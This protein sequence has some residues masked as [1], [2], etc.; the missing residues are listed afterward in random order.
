MNDV[1]R[2]KCPIC[3]SDRIKFV[4]RPQV[5]KETSSYIR[6]D[7]RIAMC[8]SCIFYFVHPEID[9][10]QEEWGKLYGQGYFLENPAWWDR[11]RAEH[12]QK[13]LAWLEQFA[14]GRISRFLDIG[15][16]EGYVL[17]DARARGWE[18]NGLDIHDSRK[19]CAKTDGIS[20]FEGNIFEAA[21]PDNHF[22]AV[23]LDSV[24]EHLTDPVNHLKEINRILRDGG[25]LYVGIPNENCL[26]NDFRK[27]AFTM[28]GKGN[29]SARIK[30]FKSPFH[31][32]GFTERS[33]KKVLNEN[34][35]EVAR[36]S[37][38]AGEYEWLKPK[39]FT[40]AFIINFCALPVHLAAIPLKKRVYMDAIARK[41]VSPSRPGGHVG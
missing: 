9:L 13:R 33:I 36:F 7:F 30:P 5:S 17:A 18:V 39:L 40:R 24:L 26:F 16:G 14:V 31:V 6:Q 10:T 32:V 11:K 29:I 38:F 8:R 2:P 22:D 34:N 21:F 27:I 28:L 20:F 4:G 15:C 41:I 25:T 12:R 37:I 23:Y 1:S 35:F 19:D 3:E